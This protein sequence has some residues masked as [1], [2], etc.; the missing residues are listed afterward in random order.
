[1]IQSLY[2][3][4]NKR[5]TSKFTKK[6]LLEIPRNHLLKLTIVLDNKQANPRIKTPIRKIK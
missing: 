5:N 1:M 3:T 6:L 4:P 2:I